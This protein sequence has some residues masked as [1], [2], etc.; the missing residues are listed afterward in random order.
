MNDKFKNEIHKVIDNKD[1]EPISIHTDDNQL[2]H[3]NNLLSKLC[4]I[5][6]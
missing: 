3:L 4:N 2:F 5:A 1:L 6:K